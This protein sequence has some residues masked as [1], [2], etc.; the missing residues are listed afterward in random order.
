MIVRFNMNTHTN[1]IIRMTALDQVC[2]SAVP[3]SIF[4]F[5]FPLP[6]LFLLYS[7]S[8]AAN[9]KMRVDGL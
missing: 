5:F 9:S 8:G 3:G 4:A 7:P 1:L 6:L 2:A